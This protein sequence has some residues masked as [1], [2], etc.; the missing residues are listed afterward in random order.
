[1]GKST[2]FSEWILGV[3]EPYR[4]NKFLVMALFYLKCYQSF[5]QPAQ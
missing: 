5:K 4:E 3:W 1:M 2:D